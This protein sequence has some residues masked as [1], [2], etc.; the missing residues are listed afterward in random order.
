MRPINASRNEDGNVLFDILA[1]EEVDKTIKSYIRMTES[2]FYYLLS[3]ISH[4]VQRMD[5]VMRKAITVKERLAITLRFLATGD[6]FSS[7]HILFHL[8]STEEDWKNISD[9]FESKYGFPHVIGAI[10]GKHVAIRAPHNSGT[11]YFNYKGYFSI[12]LLAIVD[13]N[14]KFIYVDVGCKGRISDGGVLRQSEIYN[15]LERD[16]LNIPPP[17]KLSPHH[18]IAVPY[19][20]LGDKAFPLK[21]YCLRP[22]S[23]RNTQSS[24]IEGNFNIHHSVARLP[25]ESAFGQ[26]STR[27]RVLLTTMQLAPEIATKITLSCVYL[28]NFLKT[29]M[30]P[31][32]IT[33][34]SNDT[35]S[36]VI[37]SQQLSGIANRSSGELMAIRNCIANYLY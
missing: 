21:K 24:S 4:N 19:M 31:D 33:S 32:I 37:T 1:A 12:V 13:S 17:S 23:M 5:T 27:F 29:I 11:D 8:P 35:N 6:S 18:T 2:D 26:L 20:L 16:E 3:L 15:M 22:Y 9:G 30:S 10:D 28:H 34:I 7:L 14:C 25:V 36:N